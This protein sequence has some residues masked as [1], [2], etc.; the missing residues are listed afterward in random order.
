M[1]IRRIFSLIV[2]LIALSC[3]SNN[4]HFESDEVSGA[5]V[6]EYTFKV[7]NPES[8]TEI[9]MRTIRDTI[10]IQ[11]IN[12]DYEVSNNRWGLNDYDKDGWRNME[13]ADDRPLPTYVATYESKTH[14]LKAV[15]TA[16]N[17]IH[18]DIE[19]NQLYWAKD[20]PYK[21]ITGD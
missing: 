13:H 5:Y 15:G 4:N 9:G 7:I 16:S 18:L 2:G 12:K 6:R 10:I 8:G 17:I 11:P 20:K 19:T 21:K 1:K 3:G 14:S